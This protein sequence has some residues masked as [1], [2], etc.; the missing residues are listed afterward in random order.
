MQAGVNGGNTAWRVRRGEKE[1]MAWLRSKDS[2]R[3]NPA[4]A[5]SREILRRRCSPAGV[6]AMSGSPLPSRPTPDDIPF[7]RVDPSVN[8]RKGKRLR[9]LFPRCSNALEK[10]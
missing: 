6:M 4:S 5:P 3:E 2:N 7:V 10:L 9:R 8:P 1:G